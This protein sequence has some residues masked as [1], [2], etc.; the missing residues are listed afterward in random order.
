MPVSGQRTDRAGG[1][2]NLYPTVRDAA[3][4]V[5]SAATG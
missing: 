5:Q 3:A 4:A 2:Q 1:E